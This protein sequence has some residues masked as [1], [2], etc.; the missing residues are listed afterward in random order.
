MGSKILKRNQPCINPTC[1]SHDAR[2]VYEKG[3]SFCFSCREFFTKEQGEAVAD[4][5]VEPTITLSKSSSQIRV[6]KEDISDIS[7]YRSVPFK[8]RKISKDVVEFFNVK[9]SFNSDGEMHSHYYPYGDGAYK[10]RVLPKK[11][12]YWLGEKP[13]TLFG[14]D[15]FNGDGRRLIIV[16]GEI[17][18][19]SIAEASFN[20]YGKIYPVVGLSSSTDTKPLIQNR[21]WIRSFNEVILCLDED[22]PGRKAVEDCIKII[23]ID[24]VKIT[25]LAHK[26]ANE[27]LLKEG[28]QKLIQYIFDAAR[29]V[30]SGIIQK[31]E[32]WEQL[33]TYNSIPAVPYPP[34]IEGINQK[35]KG[36][37]FGEIT[38]FISGTGSGKSTLLREDMLHVLGTTD[39]KIG[40]VS[41][42]E[43]PAETARKLCGMA[44]LK[45]PEHEEIPLEELKIGFDSVFGSDRIVL[46][47][48][49]GSIDDSSIIDKLEYMCLTDCRFIYIDH[50]TILVSEGMENLKGNEAQDKVMNDLLRLVKRHPVWIGLVSHLRKASTGGKSFEEGK[51]PSLDD[52]KG[53]GSI[54]QISFDV[55]S[56]ARNLTAANELERNT[57]KMRVLK[58]RRTGLT[59]V[60]PSARYNQHTGRLSATDF[61]CEEEFVQI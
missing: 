30:P 37:R 40:I 20:K 38:T 50:I 29:H 57:I 47:D 51:L 26:D 31:E 17:D 3:D 32:L 58:A 61:C 18:V 10:V 16:E 5:K 44:L 12:F 22:E 33:V 54:K 27:V 13:K 4:F 28:P 43:S 35:L 1:G 23:G 49:Q 55:I 6:K 46:L 8:D 56:F 24:K 39:Y 15:K 36:K 34:C 42:E 52:I 14:Q 59:G 7:G 2:Q 60:V 11:D 53:S 25:K 19:L 48:H 41:L 21:E 45:N 9:A